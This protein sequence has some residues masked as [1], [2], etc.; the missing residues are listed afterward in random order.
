M[1]QSLMLNSLLDLSLFGDALAALAYAVFTLYF[2]WKLCWQRSAPAHS[3]SY[4]F[5]SALLVS[6]GWAAFSWLTQW[7]R[8][9]IEVDVWLIPLADWLRYALWLAFVCLLLRPA[10]GGARAAGLPRFAP[11]AVVVSLTSLAFL[12]SREYSS[13]WL[14]WPVMLSRP[15]AFAALAQAVVGLIL[16]EQLLRNVSADSRWNAKPVCLG[17]SAIFAFDLFFFSQA[18]L[19]RRFDSDAL[20]VRALVHSLAVP[21]LFMAARRQVDWLDKLHVSRA[22]VFHSAAL[23]LVG[24]YLLLVSAV[25][26]YVRYTGGEWGRALQLALM[27][28]A[29]IALA[30]AVLSGAI[31]ARLKIYISKNFFNYRYDYREEWLRF[32]AILSSGSSPQEMGLTVVKALA[33]LV[34]APSGALWLRRGAEA[35]LRPVANWNLPQQ[36]RA[37][38]AASGFCEFLRERNW[39]VDIQQLHAQHQHYQAVALPEWLLADSRYWLVIPLIVGGELLGLVVLGRPRAPIEVNWEVRD[40]LKTASSQ[41][42]SYLAQMQAAEALIEAR[43]FDAFNRMSAFVVHDLKNIVT[44][45]S[46]MMKNAKRLRDNPEFQQDMLDTVENS[47]EKM[48][49]LMLQLREGEKPHGVSSGVDLVGIAKRLAAAAEAKGRRLNLQ[50]SQGLRTRGHEDRVER[51]IGHV[52][53]NAFD[54]SAA[55]A[56]VRLVLEQNGSMAR[57]IVSDQG[58]GM[59]EDFIQNRLFKPFQTTKSSGMGIGAYESYQ[60]LQ[61]LGGKISVDSKLK[62]GTTVTISLPL[63]HGGGAGEHS[64]VGGA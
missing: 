40:L 49:Q 3:V 36:D 19:F 48:R 47:L 43:K 29:L 17:L 37:E 53:Q 55:D 20:S 7:L 13:P 59:S 44:Q 8:L 12:I 27:F 52:V 45:L 64:L 16:V 10:D 50:L 15:A 63:F 21:L 4:V 24:A 26:Y 46:L 58:C 51:V 31:R 30:V 41:A 33:N 38:H 9:P 32:T 61:E 60:Y 18:A 39:I 54:A 28:V 25:G 57:L 23:L 14:S 35:E 34:E 62:I 11:L 2:A 22:A 1:L 56:E 42:A 6:T 5:L